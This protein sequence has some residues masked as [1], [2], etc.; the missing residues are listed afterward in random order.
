M[1]ALRIMAGMLLAVVLVAGIP[2]AASALPISGPVAA[3]APPGFDP[4]SNKWRGFMVNILGSVLGPATPNKYRAEIIANQYALRHSPDALAAATGIGRGNPL[5]RIPETIED[6]T[7][8]EYERQV[9]RGTVAK[10][11]GSG[12]RGAIRVPSTAAAGVVRT[13]GGVGTALLGLEV[14]TALGAAGSDALGAWLGFDA[15][16]LV[17]AQAV[18]SPAGVLTEWVTGRDC[19][20]WSFGEDYIVNKDQPVQYGNLV[21]GGYTG[22]FL[23]VYRPN[24]WPNANWFEAACY[25]HTGTL[26]TGY[27]IGYKTAGGAFIE[28]GLGG[29]PFT[30]S[31]SAYCTSP[32]GLKYYYGRDGQ[33]TWHNGSANVNAGWPA[34]MLQYTPPGGGTPTYTTMPETASDPNRR[35]DCKVTYTDGTSSTV[36]GAIYKETEGAVEPPTC[37]A[38]PANKVPSDVAI[39]EN[40]PGTAT[41]PNTVYNEPTTPESQDFQENYPECGNGTCLLD[42][43]KIIPGSG[44]VSCFDLTDGCPGWF[45]DPA[46]A[47]TYKCIYGSEVVALAECNLYSGLFTP[48]RVEIGS[49]YS[50]PAT[51]TWSGGQTAPKSGQEAMGATIRDPDLGPRSCDF[52]GLGFDPVGWVLKP[53]QCGLEWA[54]V[55]RASRVELTFAGTANAWEGKPPQVIAAAVETVAVAAPASGCSVG[56]TLFGV[57]ADIVN[58]CSG[59]MAALPVVSRLVISAFMVVMVFNLVRRQI[60]GMVGYNLGQG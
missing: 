13:V 42:L 51:G 50:D 28:A 12:W 8:Q 3:A 36:A 56:V 26:P 29:S 57:N 35:L 49:P 15:Q 30:A 39:T 17:C 18:G 16:G 10:R 6:Y 24:Q 5:D 25:R 52:S 34:L 54:F 33:G 44:V 4:S 1:R 22:S 31:G 58:V 60:A 47:D 27:K 9:Q 55:P 11:A 23:H 37:P 43:V 7:A 40:F 46:K 41:P 2:S 21:A 32:T 45:E 14:G 38:T 48:Q 59:P 20:A 53:I 19:S